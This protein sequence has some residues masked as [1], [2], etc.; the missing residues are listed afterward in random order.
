MK[1][2][3][4]IGNAHGSAYTMIY[5]PQNAAPPSKLTMLL[6]SPPSY[7]WTSFHSWQ[8]YKEGNLTYTTLHGTA[9]L[10]TW[11]KKLGPICGHVLTLHPN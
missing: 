4:S 3:S 8:N 10:A 2:N 9:L 7:F 6:S 5:Q 1:L 11:K